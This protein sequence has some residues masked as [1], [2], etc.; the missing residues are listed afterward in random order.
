MVTTEDRPTPNSDS[1]QLHLLANYLES[2]TPY[3]VHVDDYLHTLPCLMWNVGF[4]G[5]DCPDLRSSCPKGLF[6]TFSICTDIIFVGWKSMV[7]RHSSLAHRYIRAVQMCLLYDES[8]VM[9]LLASH[10]LLDLGIVLP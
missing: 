1:L 2:S 10:M 6:S 4:P 3:V 5:L 7:F 8:L 9:W